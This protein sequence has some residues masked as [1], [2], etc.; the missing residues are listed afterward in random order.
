[1]M[2]GRGNLRFWL[3][4]SVALPFFVCTTAG[5]AQAAPRALDIPAESLNQAL[6]D[7]AKQG[8]VN[9]L[10]RPELVRGRHTRALQGTM[11]PEEAAHVLIGGSGLR[12]TTDQTGALIIADATAAVSDPASSPEVVPTDAQADSSQ[13]VEEVIVTAQKRSEREFDV[14]SSVSAL[15]GEDL[16]RTQ[17][18]RFEDYLTKIPGANFLSSGEGTTQIFLRGITA[19][20][21]QASSTVG[22]YIDE[23]PYGS[24]TAFASGATSAPDLDPSDIE[25]IEIL[26]GPQGTLYGAN[27]LGGVIKFVTTQPDLS[28]FSGRLDAGSAFVDGGGTGFN[29]SGALNIPIV[30]DSVGLRVSAYT[31][32]DPGYIDDTARGLSNT[33][34]ANVQGGRASLLFEPTSNLRISLSALGQNLDLHNLSAEDVNV[35][36]LKPIYGDLNQSR[37]INSPRR[38][39]YRLYNG[40]IDLNL[41]WADIISSTSYGTFRSSVI[42]DDS[43]AYGPA[44]SFYLGTPGL[45]AKVDQPVTQSKF[46]Q[47]IRLQSPDDQTFEWRVGFFFDHEHSVQNQG[48]SA[49]YETTGA[50]F[51]APDLFNFGLTDRYNE[52]AGFGDI[53][54]HVT[55]RLSLTVG[56]RYSNNH[57]DF[58]EV[59]DGFLLPP[60]DIERSTNDSSW[61]WLVNPAFK[62]NPDFMVY[63]RVATGYRPGGPTLFVPGAG[64]ALSPF[65]EPDT[66]T[67]YELGLK[68][69]LL[70]HKLVLEAD[71]FDIDW[72]KIQ[73][74]ETIG[75]LAYITNGGSARSQGFEA[76]AT[77]MPF[78][79]FHIAGSLTYTDAKLT[80]SI[81]LAGGS[82]GDRLPAVPRWNGS[83]DASYDWL[84]ANSWEAFVGASY[85]YVGNRISDFGLLPTGTPGQRFSLGHYDVSDL[86]A[87]LTHDDFTLT[88][89]AKNVG[90]SRGIEA[91]APNTVQLAGYPYSAAIMQPRTFGLDLEKKF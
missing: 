16:R 4:C 20:T 9:V 10:F 74:N 71:V 6:R 25:R 85:R 37:Y 69:A 64:A 52:Y 33:N 26:R 62:V 5:Y 63:G 47:E 91:L 24:S 39:Q 14:P 35:P 61:T 8:G 56:A 80:Q 38:Y 27:A 54:Y 65:F 36:D 23:A 40:T 12:V 60:F 68:S 1:M 32:R 90:N 46:T 88:I 30:E 11:T 34:S 70:D 7:L 57:Q 50:P 18:D 58:H 48:V 17:S 43:E 28:S 21:A 44:A 87:G 84:L 29:L 59:Q 66:L 72:R 55:N 15:T 49:F 86:R 77:Y 51:T 75:G 73:L 82:D 79:G 89:Y 41:G 83:L 13:A 53:T 22:I 67:S 81:P 42:T 2:R 78:A 3:V 45:G 31:R 76:S 19:G